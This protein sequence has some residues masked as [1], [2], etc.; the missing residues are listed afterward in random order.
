MIP[1][2]ATILNENG[3]NVIELTFNDKKRSMDI[4][5]KEGGKGVRERSAELLFLAMAVCYTNDIYREAALREI[6][7]E[8]VEVRVR[9][10]FDG[11]PGCIAE[12]VTCDVKVAANASEQAIIDLIE[13][14]DTVA[15]M[16]NTLRAATPVGLGV[17][18]AVEA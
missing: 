12:D 1:V 18:E 4:T 5:T 2:S 3:K 15:E 7:V 9:G 10:E 16:N 11:S 8:S 14:T 17:I 6:E 13:H